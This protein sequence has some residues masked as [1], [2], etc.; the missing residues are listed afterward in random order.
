MA[1]NEDKIFIV[2]IADE[3][4]HIDYFPFHAFTWGLKTD[5]VY[6]GI[7]DP[8]YDL[9]AIGVINGTPIISFTVR[10]VQYQKVSLLSDVIANQNTF[11]FEDKLLLIHFE[12]NKTPYHFEKKELK[13]GFTIGIYRSPRDI[14]GIFQGFQYLPILN[15]S[16]V[17]KSQKDDIFNSKQVFP[18]L[19]VSF[20][21]KDMKFKNFNVGQ[22]VSKKNGGFVR[23]LSWTGVDATQALYDDFTVDHQGVISTTNEGHDITVNIKDLRTTLSDK[24][25]SNVLNNNNFPFIKDGTYTK[26]QV[27]GKTKEIPCICL[28]EDVNKNIDVINNP[29]TSSDY[30]FMICDISQRTIDIASITDIYIEN[31]LTDIVPISQVQFDTDP[32]LNNQIAFF[33][34]SQDHF[35]KIETN[36]SQVVTRIRWENQSKVSID[37]AGYLNDSNVLIENGLEVMRTII[38]DVLAKPF[39]PAFFDVPT[40]SFFEA[41]AYN[42]QYYLSDPTSLQNQLEVLQNS[43]LGRFVYDKDLK[44][45]FDNDDFVSTLFKIP[46]TQFFPLDYKLSIESDASKV[47]NT[48][49]VG[50]QKRWAVKDDTLRHEWFKDTS[51]SDNAVLNYNSFVE[52]DFPTL[53]T[54]ITDATDFGTRLLFD[55]GDSSDTFVIKSLWDYR[56]LKGGDFVEVQ[57]DLVDQKYL[58]DVICQVESVVP[59][60]KEWQTALKLRIKEFLDSDPLENNYPLDNMIFYTKSEDNDNWRKTPEKGT[61]W[62]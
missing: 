15:D 26:P 55:V 20:E 46:K 54:N 10:Q 40:W 39:I 56:N 36:D 8:D 51:N 24:S 3:L 9:E 11:F 29:G 49:R 17:I 37:C 47:L 4:N 61:A 32:A 41:T 25:P 28:N 59:N 19:K 50:F 58:G 5:N 62:T 43:Q 35:R 52:K 60:V 13:I 31:E 27:W 45:S 34:L 44:F 22:G 14:S 6:T 38:L 7:S 42:V 33:T 18:N 48:Y 21:N 12:D 30:I 1:D 23:L 53:L 16:P 57:A 2:E